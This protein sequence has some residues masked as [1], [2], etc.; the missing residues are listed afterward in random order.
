METT[1]E[2]LVQMIAS[3]V[4]ER[5][6]R[7]FAGLVQELSVFMNFATGQRP[8]AGGYVPAKA[9]AVNAS[10]A[11][12]PSTNPQAP[13]PAKPFPVAPQTNAFGVPLPVHPDS[14]HEQTQQEDYLW[15]V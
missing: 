12:A 3:G 14:H 13:E 5:H 10:S 6:P 9:A 11:S 1:I 4:F 7:L 2:P 8:E 15:G